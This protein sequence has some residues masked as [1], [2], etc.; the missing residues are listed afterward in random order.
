MSYNAREAE[1]RKAADYIKE[2]RRSRLYSRYCVLEGYGL[3]VLEDI[4]NAALDEDANATL[5]G[6]VSASDSGMFYQ[7]ILFGNKEART[8]G[9][10]KIS[11][12]GSSM[13]AASPL[14]AEQY[15]QQ[16]Q[17]HLH[18]LEEGGSGGGKS[19]SRACT[20]CG[21]TGHT[22]FNCQARTA[23]GTHLRSITTEET[24]G[25]SAPPLHKSLP[26]TVVFQ[27]PENKVGAL[28]GKGGYVIK[29]LHEK[30]GATID[31]PM[32]RSADGIK[33]IQVS[34]PTKESI[35]HAI[36]EMNTLLHMKS[37]KIA[38]KS[39]QLQRAAYYKEGEG[40]EETDGFDYTSTG[41]T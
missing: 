6:G 39:K 13:I 22:S 32:S 28:I 9:T 21:Q 10:E 4:V 37:I 1:K 38:A 23:S 26:Q 7:A 40:D 8:R 35:E 24:S 30:T 29:K 16:Q 41:S 19:F 5:V 25:F 31:V 11:T 20:I 27:V 12:Q 33:R 3:H 36:Q 34:G 2:I 14:R 15:Q 18:H 17:Q